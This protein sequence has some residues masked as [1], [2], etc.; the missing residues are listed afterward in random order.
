MGYKRAGLR[1]ALLLLGLLSIYVAGRIIRAQLSRPG[2]SDDE[3][4]LIRQL[5]ASEDPGLAE[6]LD[7]SMVYIP[8]G[9]FLMG[10]DDARANERPQRLVYLDAYEIDRYEVTHA[11]YQ[12]FVKATG[13]TPPRY[14]SGNDYPQGMIDFPVAGVG[15]QDADAY[16]MWAEKRLP[17]EA[18]WEKA[19]RGTGGRIYPWG[20]TWHPDRANVGPPLE[21]ARS[22]V[23][24]EAWAY[25][26]A[27]PTDSGMP[28]LRPVGTYPESASPYGVM[29]L[30]GNVSEWVQDWYNWSDYRDLPTRNPQ[31]Q[32]PP[33]N[34][35]LRGSSWFIPY[36][37]NA[38]GQD[39]SRCS[40]RNSSHGA[41]GDVRS[42][43]RCARSVL[44]GTP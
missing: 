37:D 17:T 19:C 23:W 22:G 28:G 7:R 12:R 6:A 42:G 41:H 10:S 27:N 32:G 8:A 33:W 38:Q 4:E 2:F 16:C 30:A 43:F 44:E 29:D 18:E 21:D 24:D 26:Q 3:L 9:E 25:V 39:Q 36:G 35:C 11:Q 15:W 31:V 20:N 5:A 13:Y 14:W 34:R 1:I 40:A